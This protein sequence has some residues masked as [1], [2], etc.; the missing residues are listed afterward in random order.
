[1]AEKKTGKKVVRRVLNY[2]WIVKNIGFFLFV[3]LLMVLYIANGHYAD[4]T[5]RNI[6]KTSKEIKELEYEYKTLKSEMM[7]KS[8]ETEMIRAAAPLGLKINET[9]P[10]RLKQ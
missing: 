9:P 8:R 6:S 1:M 4:K 7:F 5:I 10:M 2:K 3:A